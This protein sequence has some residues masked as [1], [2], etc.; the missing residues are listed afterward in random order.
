MGRASSPAAARAWSAEPARRSAEH[1]HRRQTAEQTQPAAEQPRIPPTSSSRTPVRGIFGAIEQLFGDTE[2]GVVQR[3]ARR[4]RTVH[5][6]EASAISRLQ[7]QLRNVELAAGGAA[8]ELLRILSD[9]RHALHGS[10]LE[11][12][13]DLADRMGEARAAAWRGSQDLVRLRSGSG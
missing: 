9:Q 11:V 1:L 5:R 3:L 6:G 7:Q 13:E 4:R 12:L 10:D 2:S 8:A